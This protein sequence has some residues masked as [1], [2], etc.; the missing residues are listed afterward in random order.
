MGLVLSQQ[1]DS[2]FQ[3]IVVDAHFPNLSLGLYLTNQI[4]RAHHGTLT[5]HS[6]NDHETLLTR[7][8]SVEEEE[9]IV[10]NGM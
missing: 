1:V 7:A 5:V 4:A 2:L 10:S 6:P 9:L 3:P 8:L